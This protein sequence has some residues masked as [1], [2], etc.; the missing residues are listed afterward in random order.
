VNPSDEDS[1]EEQMRHYLFK[2]G[3]DKDDPDHWAHVAVHLPGWRWVSGM[4]AFELPRTYDEG[5][6]IGRYRVQDNQHGTRLVDLSHRNHYEDQPIDQSIVMISNGFPFLVDMADAGTVGGLL[7]LCGDA[8]ELVTMR[9]ICGKPA[10]WRVTFIGCAADIDGK[11]Y[12][13]HDRLLSVAIVKAAQ[14]RG[15]W[16]G[17]EA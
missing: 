2:I 10:G 17:G 9:A 5:G 12:T 15:S 4:A 3:R 6:P 14:A 13:A 16:P 1:Y 7:A 8:I 11:S